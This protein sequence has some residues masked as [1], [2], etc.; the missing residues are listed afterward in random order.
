MSFVRRVGGGSYR[1]KNLLGLF[2]LS[3][4][5]STPLRDS[6][7]LRFVV[8]NFVVVGPPAVSAIVSSKGPIEFALHFLSLLL[9][10]R[11]GVE[12]AGTDEIV[13]GLSFV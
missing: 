7:H 10:I 12:E 8:K 9:K 6:V 2:V 11:R 5:L 1:V 4:L 13:G 3:I